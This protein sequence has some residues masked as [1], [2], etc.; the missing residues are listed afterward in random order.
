MPKEGIFHLGAGQGEKDGARGDPN[1]VECKGRAELRFLLSNG[2]RS[3][4]K[5]K[6]RAKPQG[7]VN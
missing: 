1:E 7:E 3:K 2:C 5:S 4:S 6:S